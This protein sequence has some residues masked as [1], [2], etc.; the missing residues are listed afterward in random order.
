MTDREAVLIVRGSAPAVSAARAVGEKHGIPV[1]TETVDGMYG[2]DAEVLNAVI[3][4][5]APPE[6]P[7]PVLFESNPH[8]AKKLKGR[9]RRKW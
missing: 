7:E 9:N 1:I 4:L 8:R 3:T 5:T 2:T 6:H